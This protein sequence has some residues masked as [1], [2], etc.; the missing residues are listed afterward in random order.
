MTAPNPPIP[1]DIVEATKLSIAARYDEGKLTAIDSGAVSNLML[2]AKL[3]EKKRQA[4]IN[5]DEDKDNTSQRAYLDLLI[6][7]GMTPLG[8]KQLEDKKV[9][10]NGKLADRR[11]IDKR[12]T[13]TD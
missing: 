6:Q 5:G 8:R 11:K 12:P 9:Q 7:L 13:P 10:S 3:L 1:E 2:L 4:L